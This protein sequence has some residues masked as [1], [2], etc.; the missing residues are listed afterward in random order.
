MHYEIVFILFYFYIL[1][2]SHI[3]FSVILLPC[4]Q[5][6]DPAH[7][8]FESLK[9]IKHFDKIVHQMKTFFQNIF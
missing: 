5:N 2:Y 4:V 3:H 8:C 6:T 9:E 1:N 7:L